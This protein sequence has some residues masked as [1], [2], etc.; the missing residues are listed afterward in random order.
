MLLFELLLT[1]LKGILI[2]M[3]VSAPMGPTGLLCLR[4]T[5][6]AGRKQGMLVG[7]G[8]TL[9]DLVYGL[10]AYWGVG[11]VLNLLDHY[12]SSLRLGGSIFILAFCVILLTR[13]VAP[14]EDDEP[15][16]IHPLKSV[17]SVKKVSGAFLLTLSNPFIILLFL[18]LYTRLEFVR[19]AKLQFIEFFVAMAGIGIGC[20]LWWIILICRHGWHRYR[21]YPLVDYPYLCGQEALPTLR[22]AEPRVDQSPS[23]LCPDRDRRSRGLLGSL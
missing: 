21:M 3:L 15:V 16:Q 18:P 12:S 17:H 11:I 2:G 9:S 6:R 10:V 20:V 14:R 8:A 1:F 23:S 4:E 5:T 7:L 22:C 13:R 19:V